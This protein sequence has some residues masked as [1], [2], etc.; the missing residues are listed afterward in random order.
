MDEFISISK[1]NHELTNAGIVP[2][3]SVANPHK[4]TTLVWLPYQ[5]S[6]GLKLGRLL[7][8]YR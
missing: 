8:R 7:D 2:R 4:N 3:Y 6:V 1:T 5:G